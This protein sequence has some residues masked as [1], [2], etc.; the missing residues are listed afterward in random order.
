MTVTAAE[1]VK[2]KE[3][4]P[5]TYPEESLVGVRVTAGPSAVP[6]ELLKVTVPVGGLPRLPPEGLEGERVSTN[7]VTVT[8]APVATVVVEVVS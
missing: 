1:G 7:A 5:A 6:V 8:G 2:V 3:A 4:V